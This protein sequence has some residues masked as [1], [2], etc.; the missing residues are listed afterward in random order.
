MKSEVIDLTG[1]GDALTAAVIFGLLND[2]SVNEAVQLGVSAAA[3]TL[4]CRET[5][6]TDLSL[7]ILYD[8]LI[9]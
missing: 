3:L 7:E 5:V 1:A 9:V 4:Q 2:F 8:K 6:C